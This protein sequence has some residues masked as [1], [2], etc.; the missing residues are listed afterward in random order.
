M[1]VNQNDRLVL[2]GLHGSD[3]DRAAEAYAVDDLEP[4]RNSLISYLG[5]SALG[6]ILL[7]SLE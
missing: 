2:L 4:S 1:K 7:S 6:T 5:T 3:L